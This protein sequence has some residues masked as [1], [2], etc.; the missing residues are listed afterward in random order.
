M[1]ATGW[2]PALSTRETDV[3]E[4]EGGAAT[5]VAPSKVPFLAFSFG[6]DSSNKMESCFSH[7][8]NSMV[9]L[10]VAAGEGEVAVS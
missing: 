6:V 2:S 8:R 4:Q 10:G 7:K 9:K 5:Q 1:A 3:L